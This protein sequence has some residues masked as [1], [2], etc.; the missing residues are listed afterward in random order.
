MASETNWKPVQLDEAFFGAG[1]PQDLIGIEECTDYELINVVPAKKRA[2]SKASSVP[3]KKKV[4]NINAETIS[5]SRSGSTLNSDETCVENS[6]AENIWTSFSLPESILRALKEQGFVYPT[7]IQLKTLPAAIL[8]RRD[9]LGAAQTGSGK[10]L[11]FGIPILTGILKLKEQGKSPVNDPVKPLY[12]LILTPTRELAM[13]IK[14]HL[15]SIAKY[16]KIQI[17]VVVG[18]MAAEKQERILGKEPEVVVA[19]PGRLW[20]LIQQGNPHLLKVASI[21]FL[22]IDETDR[23]LER[24]HFQELHSL[25]EKI[26]LDDDKRKARQNFVFSATLTLVH[27]L[28]KHLTK[29]KFRKI[30]SMTPEQKLQK[31]MDSLGVTKPKV[32]DISEGKGTSETLTECRISCALH[33]KDY[34]VYYFLRR[35]PGRTLIFCNSIGCVKRLS[36]LLNLLEC[37][38]LPLH[39]NMQQRQRLK[40]LDKFRDTENSILVATDVA[41]RGLDIPKI[42]HVLHYQTPRTSESYVHRSGRTARAAKQGITV[43]IMEPNEFQNYIKLCRTLGK[44][45]DLP[46]FPVEDKYLNAVKKIVNI[47][48]ELDKIQLQ[49]RKANSEEGW[50]QKAAH[51]MDIVVDGILKKYDLDETRHQRKGAEMKRK[52]LSSL[53]SKPIFPKGFTGKFSVVSGQ[54]SFPISGMTQNKGSAIDAVR[55]STQAAVTRK[56]R[57]IPLFQPAKHAR[58]VKNTSHGFKGSNFVKRTRKV[59]HKRKR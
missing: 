25:L 52:H 57:Q 44:E 50:L 46:L 28:P 26:N 34:Y 42:D 35:H 29:K 41:A 15:S 21:K 4:E 19:T 56:Q 13:Q 11:A 2:K 22:A 16:T 3:K 23:M 43:L 18:G 1:V 6:E 9:I 31:I 55:D 12:A 40:N 8:G 32:V 39:A 51:D 10:T 7:E 37:R 17:A 49:V 27:D 58:K 36:N 45:N 47:A 24:D 30:G 53:L 48:R 20:E 54:E 59:H 38:C 33:E 5:P 14:N